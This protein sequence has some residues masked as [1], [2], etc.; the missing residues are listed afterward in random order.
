[1]Q[2]AFMEIHKHGYQGMRIDQVLSITGLKK[3]A[4]YH[5][6]SSKQALGYAVLE[7]CIQQRISQ[8]WIVP[9]TS[10]ADPLEGIHS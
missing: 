10:L 1:M 9:L 6:F 4:L 8:L 5:H 2:A 7:E 3:G